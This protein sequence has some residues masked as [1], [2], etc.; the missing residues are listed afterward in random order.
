MFVH[1]CFWHRHPACALAR[2]PKSRIDFW[3]RKLNGNRERD[4][5]NQKKLIELG[6]GY[7]TVW[8]CELRDSDELTSR[9]RSFLGDLRP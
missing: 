8:E 4:L 2:I 3:K 6:W 7:M 9:I 5:A 1:G